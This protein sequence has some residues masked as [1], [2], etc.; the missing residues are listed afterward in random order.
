MA[1]AVFLLRVQ[2][3]HYAVSSGTSMGDA[4]RVFHLVHLNDVVQLALFH[5]LP[6]R[7]EGDIEDGAL[8]KHSVGRCC[9]LC[10]VHSAGC[11]LTPDG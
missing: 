4:H 6:I 7:P 8:A 10:G 2:F 5:A 9:P 1:G 3:D 11:S